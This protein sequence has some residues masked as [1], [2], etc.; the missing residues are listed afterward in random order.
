M[1][2]LDLP[3]GKLRRQPGLSDTRERILL[4]AEQLFA[5]HGIEAI[6]LQR[7]VEAAGHR[8]TSAVQYY[9]GS[10]NEL[11]KAILAFRQQHFDVQRLALIAEMTR[12]DRGLDLRGFVESM[13]YPLAHSV[14]PGSTFVR[15][16]ALAIYD[17]VKRY[18]PREDSDNVDGIRAI[19]AGIIAA[20]HH[21]PPRVRQ[22]RYLLAWRMVIQTL[23][24]HEH[25]IESRQHYVM[26]TQALAAD[27]TECILGMLQAPS[28][29]KQKPAVRG[30]KSQAPKTQS[31]LKKS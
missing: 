22:Q 10:K 23:A 19:E 13:V 17:P 2:K 28:S 4:A 21:L 20:L 27:L 11:I 15:F 8:N 16:V 12:N 9:F 7:I 31:A 6:S 26:P 3:E 18:I 25:D 5:Q 1:R 14:R 29:A 30:K 24:H